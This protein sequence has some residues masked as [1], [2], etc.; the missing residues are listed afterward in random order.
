MVRIYTRTGD[1]GETGLFDGTRVSKADPRV[2]AYGDVDELASW[3]G[4]VRARTGLVRSRGDGHAPSARS[5]C[6]RRASRRPAAQ[7]SPA[8]SRKR[9]LTEDDVTRLEGWIDA[10]EAEL[11]PLRR[12]ILAG[13]NDAGA[14][15][16]FARA[17]CRRAERRMVA[18][19]PRRRRGGRARVHQPVVGSAV[20][21]G[22][23]RQRARRGR[24]R[25]VVAE[26]AY[27]ACLRLA[28]Q[29]YENFP[30][31]SRLMPPASRPH[32][33]AIY[34]FARMADDFADEGDR[35]RR[36][37]RLARLD[38]WRERL[39]A[40]AAGRPWRRATMPMRRRSSRRSPRP[41]PCIASMCRLFDDLLSAFR[42]DVV[43]TRYETWERLL[44]YCRRSANPIGR[45][46]LA[47]TGYRDPNA[48]PHDPTPSAR[49]CS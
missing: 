6:P 15:F 28:R 44:D 3:L 49:H 18:L 22:A 32:I 25:R 20:H 1:A 27:A 2:D 26:A 14:G 33:A 12:F 47:V 38:E 13:G 17:I 40:A 31:A 43:T 30:V 21:H 5:V 8:A 11:P 23:R 24:R 39:H 10:L 34:A 45:L 42:Q 48:R 19:G 46:V 29:H 37:S 41:W 36:E 16:H 9:S 4:V 7:R 35:R